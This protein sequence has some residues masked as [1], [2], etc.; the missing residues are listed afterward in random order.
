VWSRVSVA[1]LSVK[2]KVLLA[3]GVF[4]I[5]L[6]VTSVVLGSRGW[7]D[8][9]RMRRE[10][11]SLEQE[12]VRL[13]A[14]NARQREHLRRLDGDDAYAERVVREKLGWAKPGELVYRVRGPVAGPAPCASRQER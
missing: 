13:Q 14:A 12:A 1:S 9:R 2:H 11:A 7:L 6:C 5:L 10:Q 8:L 4:A 3:G